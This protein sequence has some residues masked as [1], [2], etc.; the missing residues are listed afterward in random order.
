MK[1]DPDVDRYFSGSIYRI[2]SS[3]FGFFLTLLGVYVVFFGVV[4]PVIR[5]AIGLLITLFGPEAIWSSIPSRQSWLAKL[6]PFF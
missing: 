4:E 3:L 6:G 2:L 1:N 5:I